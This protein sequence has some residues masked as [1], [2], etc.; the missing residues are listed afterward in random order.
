MLPFF[1]TGQKLEDEGYTCTFLP[2]FLRFSRADPPPF[3]SSFPAAHLLLECI[4]ASLWNAACLGYLLYSPSLASPSSSFTPSSPPSDTLV[5]TLLALVSIP[6]LIAVSA[7][8]AAIWSE[9]RVDAERRKRVGRVGKAAVW[10]GWIG[11]LLSCFPGRKMLT[12]NVSEACV[13]ALWPILFFVMSGQSAWL[14][15]YLAV[16]TGTFLPLPSFLLSPY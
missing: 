1:L 16:S 3:S 9:S 10:V 4:L 6:L 13:A 2:L 15:R 7:G 8:S 11:A 12:W 5:Y 14:Q